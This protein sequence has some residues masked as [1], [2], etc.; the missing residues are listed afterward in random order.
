ML[1]C[2]LIEDFCEFYNI[3]KFIK[4]STRF[5]NFKK[6]A[7]IDLII[8]IGPQSLYVIDVVFLVWNEKAMSRKTIGV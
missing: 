8:N 1:F 4:Q 6:P 3:T 2:S 7:C 5:I